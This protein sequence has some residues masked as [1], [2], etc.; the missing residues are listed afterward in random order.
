[1][2]FLAFCSSVS[3]AMKS[4]FTLLKASLRTSLALAWMAMS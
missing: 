2:A 1:M 4:S 3:V